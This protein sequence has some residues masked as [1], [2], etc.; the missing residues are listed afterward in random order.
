LE[1][2]SELL[3]D[4]AIQLGLEYPWLQ[5]YGVC[6]DFKHSWSYLDDLPAGKRVVFYP[7]STLGNLEPGAA[8]GFLAHVRQVIGE[9]GGLLI[10]VDM[11]KS[12]GILHAAYNDNQGITAEFN[13]NVLSCLNELLD[14]NFDRERF[15][16]RAFYDEQK[17]RIEMHLVSETAQSVRCNGEVIHFEPGESIHT[18]NSYKYTTAGFAELAASAGLF[19]EES[20]YDADRLFGVHYLGADPAHAVTPEN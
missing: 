11:H 10:G 13:L 15:Q 17:Q 5:V 1:I 7:G 8:A 9:G 4:E 2:S 14:A 6:T 18:E 3:N 19:I 16:H 20:W 12:T